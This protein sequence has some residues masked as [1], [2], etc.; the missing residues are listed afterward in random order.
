MI[1]EEQRLALLTLVKRECPDCG[2][3]HPLEFWVE[4]LEELPILEAK[5]PNLV[6]GF[7]L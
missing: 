4:M 5:Q 7:C 6:N 1:D 2:N 3:H